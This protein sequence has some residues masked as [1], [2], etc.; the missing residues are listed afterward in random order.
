MRPG[1]VRLTSKPQDAT[2]L[3]ATPETADQCSKELAEGSFGES[4]QKAF[5]TVVGTTEATLVL[6]KEH[7]EEFLPCLAAK[8]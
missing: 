7:P 4:A 8:S 1:P 5:Q 6:Q 3:H 2:C